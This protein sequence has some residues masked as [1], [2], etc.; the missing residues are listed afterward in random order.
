MRKGLFGLPI[1]LTLAVALVAPPDAS[2][3]ASRTKAAP[4]QELLQ[5]DLDVEEL[6]PGQ[7]QRAQEP[8][9]PPAARTAPPRQP[10]GRQSA[11]QQSAPQQSAPPQQAGRA[12][13]CNG[14]FA[15]D[16]SHVKLAMLFGTQN[17]TYTE[18]DGPESSKLM[19]SVVYPQ[20]PKRRL[21]VL[22]QDEVTR[23][24]TSLIVITGQ[25]AWTAP[26]GLHLGLALAAVEKLNGKPFRL[27]GFDGGGQVVDWQKGALESLPGGCKVSVRLAPDPKAAP[28]AIAEATAE[29]EFLSTDPA[30][31]AARP[32]VAEILLGY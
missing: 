28:S 20:D 25:S 7:I 2:A 30:M 5:P 14:A 16:S 26:K 3:Q 18:V 24:N 12:V 22:W 6:T 1:G 15:K 31:R 29:K 32:T 4:R 11:P 19:A 27:M 13:A 10:A 9:T 21:E 17:V 23:N 8:L